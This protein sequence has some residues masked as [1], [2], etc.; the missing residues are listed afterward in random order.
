MQ[1]TVAKSTAI[2]VTLTAHS[3]YEYRCGNGAWQSDPHFAGLTPDTPYTFYQRV[4][5]MVSDAL[6]VKTDKVRNVESPVVVDYTGDSV[7][8]WAF[9][10]YEYRCN[11]GKWQS[12]PTFTG[13]EPET[14]YTFSQ[15]LTMT[16]ETSRAITAK[17]DKYDTTNLAKLIAF[18]TLYG[19]ENYNGEIVYTISEGSPDKVT[20]SMRVKKNRNSVEDMYV[21]FEASVLYNANTF[22]NYVGIAVFPFDT[23]TVGECQ[24]EMDIGQYSGSTSG[25]F[26]FDRAKYT[27]SYTCTV[28]DIKADSIYGDALPLEENTQTLLAQMMTRFDELLYEK[29]GFGIKGIGF[30]S[31]EGKGDDYCDPWV[32]YHI[33]GTEVRNKREATCVVDGNT[34][35]TYCAACRQKI[36]SGTVI[37]ALGGHT[38]SDGADKD[39]NV[40]AAACAS[41]VHKYDND[42]DTTCNRCGAYAARSVIGDV[43]GDSKVDSTDARLVLQYAVKK[44]GT[45]ALNVAVADVDGNGKIDSTDARL[46]LQYAVKKITTF[47]AA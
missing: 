14:V 41:G 34:G 27:A 12:S 30:V 44:I 28:T 6:T 33:G 9:E 37:P 29:I 24:M 35:D 32:N 4:S 15:R 23:Y 39:C 25:K 42:R 2:S 19:K 26:S 11:N 17:T 16:G 45:S 22:L 20:Y 8:L 46:I 43:N 38:Y 13:L 7:T 47:P 5:N 40:C 36:K 1:P 18:I 21:V 10:G 31:Y 3:G